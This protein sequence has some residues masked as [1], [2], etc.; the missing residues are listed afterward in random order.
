MVK[1]RLKRM[2]SKFNAFYKVVA[3]DSRAPRDGKFIEALGH[4]NPHTK[5]LVLN[6][7]ATSKWLANGAQPTVT[8]SNLFRAKKLTEKLM[9]GK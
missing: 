8:V 3:A 6:E 1:I 2:G 9:P 4:Y 7:E 5:E